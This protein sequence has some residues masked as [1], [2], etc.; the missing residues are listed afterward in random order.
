LTK[1]QKFLKNNGIINLKTDDDTLYNYT[2]KI[3]AL[4]DLELI[5]D[6]N[7]LY[8]SPY[9]TDLLTVKTHYEKIWNKAGKTIK[10]LKFRLPQNKIILE[11]NF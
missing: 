8:N 5:I 11:G 3:I 10:Y 2:K 4:N 6:T 9:Y 1:Y 7:D